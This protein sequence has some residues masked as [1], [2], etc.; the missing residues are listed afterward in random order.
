MASV[1]GFQREKYE[2]MT[3]AKCKKKKK[4]V[5]KRSTYGHKHVES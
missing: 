4:N 1:P 3:T 5:Q 2:D